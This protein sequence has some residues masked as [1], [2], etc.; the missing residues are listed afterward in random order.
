L[1]LGTYS[2][3]RVIDKLIS[4][5]P[6]PDFSDN[7]LGGPGCIVQIDETMMNYKCKSHRGRSLRNRTDTL[8]IV[9]VRGSITRAYETIIPN[10]SAAALIPIICSQVSPYS[11]IWTDKLSTYKSLNKYNY[12]HDFV[13]HKYEFVNHVTGVNTQAVEAFNNELKQEIKKRKGIK[14]ES[15]GVFLKE[16]CFYFNNRSNFLSAVLDLIKI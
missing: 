6:T 9:E 13:T 10:K 12:I 2:I 7:K 4:L 14:T 8:C 15:R 1:D 11:I 16:F 3:K 5:M